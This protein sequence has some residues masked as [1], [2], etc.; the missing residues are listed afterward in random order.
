MAAAAK[1]RSRQGSVL[2]HVFAHQEQLANAVF[3]VG[4]LTKSRFGVMMSSPPGSRGGD[5]TGQK[6][7]LLRPGRRLC[8]VSRD[9]G[10]QPSREPAPSST[11][12]VHASDRMGACTL[13]GRQRKG[14]G[15]AP[16]AAVRAED[17]RR[18]GEITVGQRPHSARHAEASGVNW[19]AVRN[20]RTGCRHGADP[21][22]SF[23]H[24]DM[25]VRSTG[26]RR[27]G[28]RYPQPRSPGTG[29]VFTTAISSWAGLD[30]HLAGRR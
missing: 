12:R 29:V 1:R 7:D 10:T 8:R 6:G 27:A 2:L 14:V 5:K 3:P 15:I 26:S 20:P 28:V 21:S 11:S 22:P 16:S 25:Y 9:G 24:P 17:R 30:R 23:R 13:H 18:A 4:G 19:I